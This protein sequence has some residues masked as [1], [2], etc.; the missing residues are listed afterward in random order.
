[1]MFHS[2]PGV[3]IKLN[4]DE[5]MAE[6]CLVWYLLAYVRRYLVVRKRGWIIEVCCCFVICH[7]SFHAICSRHTA[8]TSKQTK[9]ISHELLTK[10]IIQLYENDLITVKP[11]RWLNKMTI[12]QLHSFRINLI[13]KRFCS[14]T[15][16]LK[17]KPWD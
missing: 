5:T 4:D 11:L 15:S 9:H 16:R 6:A 10:N 2:G 12:F 14:V 13:R 17:P 7:S 8:V 3:M 1:M